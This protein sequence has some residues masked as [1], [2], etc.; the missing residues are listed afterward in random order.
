KRRLVFRVQLCLRTRAHLLQ[1]PAVSAP[2]RR[3]RFSPLTSTRP[4]H[5]RHHAETHCL[6]PFPDWDKTGLGE[7]SAPS[8]CFAYAQHFASLSSCILPHLPG[9]RINQQRT[10]RC[11]EAVE[12]P[13][14]IFIWSRSANA[15]LS[16]LKS[17][18]EFDIGRWAF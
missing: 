16:M 13:R 10:Y 5:D 3:I 2:L 18:S 7:S 6:P 14:M 12:Y 8:W 17:E 1:P 9:Y 15:Q 4:S 11:V